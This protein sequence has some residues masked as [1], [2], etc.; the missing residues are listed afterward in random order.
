MISAMTAPKTK[1]DLIQTLQAK[2]FEFS[3]HE[4]SLPSDKQKLV[5]A[6]DQQLR[7]SPVSVF[8]IREK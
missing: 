1:T 2:N 3:I 7:K 4:L 6:I 5:T 8:I